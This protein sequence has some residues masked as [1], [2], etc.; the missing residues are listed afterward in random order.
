[1]TQ[2]VLK[3]SIAHLQGFESYNGLLEPLGGIFYMIRGC[4]QRCYGGL[5]AYRRIS[6]TLRG[7][8]K[9]TYG[10]LQPAMER[11]VIALSLM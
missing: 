8:F 3:R 9:N 5:Q 7:R 6:Q 2:S 4:V 10:F 11:A 1:M